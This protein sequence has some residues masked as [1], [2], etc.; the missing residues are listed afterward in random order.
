MFVKIYNS[1][2]YY[3]PLKSL[4]TRY[5]RDSSI[6]TKHVSIYN[7]ITKA[8]RFEGDFR[9]RKGNGRRKSYAVSR[10]NDALCRL[11]LS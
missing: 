3:K 10:G 11:F 9:K 5:F 4:N 6:N 7:A 8:R 1:E 2:I